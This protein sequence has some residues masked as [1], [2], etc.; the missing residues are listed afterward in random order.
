MDRQPLTLRNDVRSPLFSRG[1]ERNEHSNI[2][3]TRNVTE[4]EPNIS[5]VRTGSVIASLRRERRD[6][7]AQV[8]ELQQK[9]A[10][11]EAE[12]CTLKDLVDKLIEALNGRK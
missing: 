8:A 5:N 2:R 1:G 11:K 6:L 10:A 12:N 3:E 4:H 9:L 7:R